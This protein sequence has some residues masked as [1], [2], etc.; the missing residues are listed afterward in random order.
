MRK[1]ERE[2][3]R[4]RQR[5]RKAR[6]KDVFVDGGLAFGTERQEGRDCEQLEGADVVVSSTRCFGE[7]KLVHGRREGRERKGRTKPPFNL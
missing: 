5:K 1:K 3:E 7:T 6:S 4:E 2:R